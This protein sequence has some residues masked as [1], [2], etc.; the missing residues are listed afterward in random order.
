MDL[1]FDDDAFFDDAGV[2]LASDVASVVVGAAVV[3]GVSA[4]VSCS[5]SLDSD[6]AGASG[7]AA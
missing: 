3:A 6:S 4:L 7:S 2:P 1:R 5:F